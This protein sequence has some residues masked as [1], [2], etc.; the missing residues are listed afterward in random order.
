MLAPVVFSTTQLNFGVN[1]GGFW[2]L[3]TFFCLG[4]YTLNN[5]VSN[6]RWHVR[7]I[8][9]HWRWKHSSRGVWKCFLLGLD[10]SYF[11]AMCFFVDPPTMGVTF[12][13]PFRSVFWWVVFWGWKFRPDWRIQVRY[14][15]HVL[16]PT[17]DITWRSLQIYVLVE[18]IGFMQKWYIY[19]YEYTHGNMQG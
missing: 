5:A 10:F 4:C 19:I 14:V 1:Q 8:D 12:Q 15:C 2:G 17:V 16:L 13:S 7:D 9:L 6:A 11:S 18:F 3:G